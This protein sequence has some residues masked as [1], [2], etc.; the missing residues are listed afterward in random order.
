MSSNLRPSVLWYYDTPEGGEP[1]L[2]YLAFAATMEENHQGQA[3]VSKYPV[4]A[5][6]MVSNH[7][8]RQNRTVNIKAYIPETMLGGINAED[9]QTGFAV[10]AMANK[11]LGVNAANVTSLVGGIVR[12]PTGVAENYLS[13]AVSEALPVVQGI[14]NGRDYIR[15]K[16][17][18]WTK[19]TKYE[20]NLETGD[21]EKIEKF[22]PSESR[23]LDAFREFVKIQQKGI[24]CELSTVLEEYSNLALISYSIPTTDS[25]LTCMLVDLTFEEVLIVDSTGSAVLTLNGATP[26]EEERADAVK[27]AEGAYDS[28]ADSAT[29]AFIDNPVKSVKDFFA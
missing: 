19:G 18:E 23:R 10:G 1:T 2:K 13:G 17:N 6:F 12:D 24:L 14:A 16:T 4:Q 3:Q 20:T 21:A 15:D 9:A 8:I 7:M 28:G 27:R 26:S 25:T 5:G 29:K 11:Y 22:L